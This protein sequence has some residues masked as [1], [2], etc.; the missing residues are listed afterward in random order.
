[1]YESW[2]R[3]TRITIIN[4]LVYYNKHVFF[5]KSINTFDKIQDI[6]HI[7]NLMDTVVEEIRLQ[8]IV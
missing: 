6:N 1:M 5:H 4:F 7:E 8:Y 3:L 2:T